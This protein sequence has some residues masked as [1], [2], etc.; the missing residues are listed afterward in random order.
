M[1][2]G[3]AFP[4]LGRHKIQH[5]LDIIKNSDQCLDLVVFPEGFETISSSYELI[6]ENIGENEE[7][8]KLL[9]KYG[10]IARNF[11]ISV[12]VGMQVFYGRESISGGSSDQYCLFIT[13]M[14]K[15]TIYHKHSTS[16][17]NAFFDTN[18]SIPNNFPV[19]QI[20]NMKMGFSI[21]HDSYISLIPRVLRTKGADVWSNISYQNVR[22]R[23][24]ESVLQTRAV[25]NDM[26]AICTLH[27]NSQA[28][29]LQ[30]E[31]YAFSPSG[32]IHLKDVETGSSL[33]DIWIENRAGK[34][35]Y[36]DSSNYDTYPLVQLTE[37]ALSSQA[38]PITISR[39]DR[40][41]GIEGGEGEFSIEEIHLQEFIFAPEKIWR[42]CLEQTNK[43]SLF[44]V[45][46]N[47]VEQWAKYKL[48]ITKLIRG[49]IIEFSTCFLFVDKEYENIFMAAYRSS[50]YKDCRI[51][52][53]EKFPVDIDKRYLFG[54]EKTYAI[55]LND[56]RKISKKVY[57]ERANQ[58][59]D[60][61]EK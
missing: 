39:G 46:V 19:V 57:F 45:I 43:I 49:R 13:S 33:S 14:G 3:L 18:W 23:I 24:W 30:K 27:R 41:I 44:F 4:E 42:M 17:Y 16:K 15:Q 53:P 35:F 40:T 11:D 28:S 59:L 22:P 37:S 50:N 26:I 29:N 25:E 58:I 1:Q 56:S 20:N 10:E 32:K 48:T 5:F 61:L 21:C 6:P 38:K 51:F 36:F 2:I 34:I 47:N 31:P 9:N 8:K 60:F 54:L 7:V 55:S 12:I 52:Y